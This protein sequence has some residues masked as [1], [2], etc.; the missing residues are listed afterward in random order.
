MIKY[1]V[2]THID[3]PANQTVT[4]EHANPLQGKGNYSYSSKCSCS[5]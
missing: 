4:K 5:M 3:Y 1:E 2:Y